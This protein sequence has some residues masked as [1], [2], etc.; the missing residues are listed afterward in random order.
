MPSNIASLLS[1]SST[2]K[3]SD[4]KAFD[5]LLIVPADKSTI[6]ARAFMSAFSNVSPL[7]A[8]LRR[9]VLIFLY[10]FGGNTEP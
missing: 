7:N 6:A 1:K 5:A 9:N 8:R 3:P 10:F 4:C 2:R